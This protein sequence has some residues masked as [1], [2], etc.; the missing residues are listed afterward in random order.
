MSHD[1]RKTLETAF[2]AYNEAI[3]EW[4][5]ECLVNSAKDLLQ[6]V[7]RHREFQGF[8]GHTQTSYSCGIYV[9]GNITHIIHQENWNA[10]PAR[11]TKVP[12]GWSVYLMRPYEGTERWVRGSV[13]VNDLSG[14]QTSINFLQGYNKAPKKGWCLVITT[15][16]EYSEI[17]ETVRGLDVL[18][19]TA[20]EAESIINRN[21]KPLQGYQ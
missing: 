4:V 16:T 9:N 7:A 12:K 21:W 15:G 5:L 14:L 8:T 11:L 13:D 10:P 17:I 20:Q 19:G 1:N 18:S 2:D 3:R 6:S